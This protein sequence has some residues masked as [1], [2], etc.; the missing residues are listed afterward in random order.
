MSKH[1]GKRKLKIRNCRARLSLLAEE[2]F[3]KLP[4]PEEND[5]DH[6]LLPI[7]TEKVGDYKNP[8]GKWSEPL[9]PPP[10]SSNYLIN[11]K[12]TL[13]I[14]M[15]PPVN[16][17]LFSLYKQNTY[18]IQYIVISSSFASKNVPIADRKCYY[19]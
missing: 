13:T 2:D 19:G 1:A 4:E 5:T 8:R 11:G 15:S 9:F 3:P 7:E 17:K 16:P 12:G 6:I 14:I 18:Q 10:K